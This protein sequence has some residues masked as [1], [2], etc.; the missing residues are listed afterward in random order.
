MPECISGTRVSVDEALR[1]E[2][3]GMPGDVLDKL[4]AEDALVLVHDNHNGICLC[5]LFIP[6]STG[7][8]TYKEVNVCIPARFVRCCIVEDAES[9]MS[10]AARLL[11]ESK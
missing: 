5:S 8:P 2:P 4:L 10:L 3:S 9:V 1:Q 7:P 11:E 6:T